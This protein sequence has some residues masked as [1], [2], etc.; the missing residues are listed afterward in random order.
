MFHMEYPCVTTGY[1]LLS[2][3]SCGLAIMYCFAR[4]ISTFTYMD[5]A[6]YRFEKIWKFPKFS[7]NLSKLPRIVLET[8]GNF[9]SLNVHMYAHACL[10]ACAHVCIANLI[11]LERATYRYATYTGFCISMGPWAFC[12]SHPPHPGSHQL[13]HVEFQLA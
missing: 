10:D 7:G 4:K 5:G 12:S 13:M 6:T 9:R 2:L 8:S 11:K 1:M 3:T